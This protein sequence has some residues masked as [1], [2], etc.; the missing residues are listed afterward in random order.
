MNPSI[1]VLVMLSF[2][3]TGPTNMLTNGDARQ[4]SAGWKTE[5]IVQ[6]VAKTEIIG[7][8]PCF[9]VRSPGSFQQRRR[10][11]RVASPQPSPGESTASGRHISATVRRAVWQRDEGRCAFVGR[12]GRCRETAFA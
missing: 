2:L 11:G 3:Q 8:V 1:A 5:G 9:A 7:G 4:G 6:G 12:T 10:F